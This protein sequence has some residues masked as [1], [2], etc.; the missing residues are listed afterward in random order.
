MDSNSITSALL[1]YKYVTTSQQE[2]RLEAVKS[3]QEDPHKDQK[4]RTIY[5]GNI[6]DELDEN[7]LI[8]IFS[9]CG[10]INLV[11]ITTDSTKLNT[12]GGANRFAFIEFADRASVHEALALS[13]LLVGDR[14]LKVGPSQGPIIQPT[15]YGPGASFMKN[16]PDLL[17]KSNPIKIVPVQPQVV[18][19]QVANDKAK[20]ALLA[21][22]EKYGKQVTETKPESTS[23]NST[24]STTATTTTTATATATTTD[25][26]EDRVHRH[27]SRSDSREIRRR[28]RSPDSRDRSYRHRSRSDSRD[29]YRDRRRHDSRDRSYRHRSR[30]DSRDR[31]RDIK[32]RR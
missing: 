4:E 15:A 21:L 30:S 14:Q 32:R 19:K 3:K 12:N 10:V 7:G 9:N 11:K 1:Q 25:K 29:R 22:Q 2:S 26:V 18:D 20:A 13:G 31:Y 5:I 8:A 27:R 17:G 6:H 16:K 28:R 24:S 23:T